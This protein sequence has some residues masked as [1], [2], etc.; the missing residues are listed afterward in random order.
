MY[1]LYAPKNTSGKNLFLRWA[2]RSLLFICVFPFL[3][4]PSQCNSCSRQ[5]IN[6]AFSELNFKI[7]ILKKWKFVTGIFFFCHV[8][9]CIHS[10]GK[11]V[12]QRFSEHTFHKQGTLLRSVPLDLPVQVERA[13]QPSV[14]ARGASHALFSGQS[15]LQLRKSW[16]WHHEP[17]TW[18]TDGGMQ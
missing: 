1:I 4:C 8:L 9:G 16:N 11:I 3:L 18:R 13:S 2:T 14:S 7:Y 12:C 17:R 15:L 6:T 10:L 5:R